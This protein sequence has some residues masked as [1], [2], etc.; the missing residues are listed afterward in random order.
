MTKPHLPR[1]QRPL[2]LAIVLLTLPALAA[3]SSLPNID[4]LLAD[5]RAPAQTTFV[6]AADGS[7]ITTLHAEEDRQIIPLGDV[8]VWV[9]NSVI[10]IED[11]RFYEHPGIDYRSVVRAFTANAKAGHVVEGGSTITQQLVKNTLIGDQRTFKRKVQEA[12]L[13]FQLE[14]KLSKDQILERYLNTVYFGRGAYGIQAAAKTFFGKDAKHLTLVDGALLAGL[15]ASPSFYDPEADPKAALARRNLVLKRMLDEHMITAK[16]EAASQRKPLGLHPQPEFSPY[17]DAYFIDYVKQRIFDGDQE[18]KMLGATRADRINAVFKGGLRIYTTIDPHLQQVAESVSKQTLPYK[19]DPYTAFVGVDPNT[20]NIVS[21]VGGRNFFDPKDPYAKFNL[22]VNSRRQPGSSFKPF[23]LAA[24]LERGISLNSI[25]R[26]GSRVYLR[27][28][29]GEVWNPGNYEGINFGGSL[30][31]LKATADSINVVYAQVVLKIG[32]EAVV[33]MAHRLG[34]TSHLDP[35][36]SIALGSEEVSPLEMAG[37][38]ST[39][40]NGGYR[41]DPAPVTKITDANGKVLYEHKVVKKRVLNPAIAALVDKALQAVMTQ[42]TGSHIQLGRPAG[43]KTGTSEEY[44]D[45]WFAGFT[46]QMVGIRWVGF[47]RAQIP[48]RPPRTRI[49]VF[50]SSWPGHMWQS[51]MIEALKGKPVVPFPTA[52]E[53]YVKVR[54]D[55][56]RNCL[57]NEFTPPYLIQE[58]S[59]FKGTEPTTI[60]KEPTSGNIDSTPNVVGE[61]S[62]IARDTLARAGFDVVSLTQ[63]CPAFVQGTVCDQAPAPGSPAQ[64]GQRAYIYV[65]NDQA[66]NQVPMVLGRTVD[67]AKQKLEEYGYKVSVV[68]KKNTDGYKGCQDTSETGSGRV[69]LQ[70]PCA[71]ADYGKGSVVT[72]FVNP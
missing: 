57:P 21:M 1:R 29:T 17:P 65:S 13:A 58:K 19:K 22:A 4:K 23:T 63:Y 26:G 37:A 35:V 38:Y 60:C 34:I 11:A 16:T 28:P 24:A 64:V 52:E 71:G 69:W 48:M 20:G 61:A 8:P 3:C 67:R 54:I 32:P 42:G 30:S 72:I 40:A 50:G 12:I 5:A 41:V 7:L 68:V 14:Q 62:S 25:W 56:S 70:N 51:W 15:V 66:V 49:T 44:H 39:F 43:G 45:A 2:A 31:L 6:Y 53:A 55:T 47:P 27:L 36:Y 59:F 18:F 10:A 9:R 33:E 46:P